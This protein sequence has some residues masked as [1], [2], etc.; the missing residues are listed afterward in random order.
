M[1]YVEVNRKG[2]LEYLEQ[3]IETFNDCSCCPRSPDCDT[4][5]YCEGRQTPSDCAEA[6]LDTVIRRSGWGGDDEW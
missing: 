1:R 5:I 6:V 3:W 4:P 2:I